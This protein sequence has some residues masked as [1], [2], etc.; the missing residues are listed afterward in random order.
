MNEVIRPTKKFQSISRRFSYAF[1]GVVTLILIAFA[2]T[3]IIVN[4][5]KI[6]SE[7]EKRLDNALKLAEISLPT[8]LW[9]LDND[10][11]DDFIE[12]LFLDESIVFV[13]VLWGG[14][15][16]SKKVRE[17]F[18]KME[19]DYFEQ[20]SKFIKRK[21]N[22]IF[23]NNKVGTIRLA[24]SM[25][26]IK[27]ELIVTISGIIA[28]TTMIII[29]IAITSLVIT[30]R[31]ITNPISRLLEATQD[32]ADGNFQQQITAMPGNEL[33]KLAHGFN[34]MAK[35]LSQLINELKYRNDLSR[36][37]ISTRVLDEI[38]ER[39]VRDVAESGGYDRVRLYLHDEKENVL[40]CQSAFG[41]EKKKLL[42]L[43]LSLSN[44]QN[45]VS[46]WVFRNKI[47]Y[48][49]DDPLN[50]DK[51]EPE[52][53]ESL[54]LN[55]YAVVPLVAGEKSL[56]VMAIDR[57][58]A[59]YPFSEDIINSLIAFA[60]TAA[61][62]IENSLLYS[63]LEK[64][65][66]ERTCQLEIANK[67]L[68][69]LDQI[70]SDF[71]S[72]VSHELRTPLTSILGFASI[73]KKRFRN[74]LIPNLDLTE[75]KVQRNTER[76][77]ESIEIII[78]EGERLSRL[79]NDVL[80]LAKIESGKMEWKSLDISVL[81]IVQQSIQT[82]SPLAKVKGLEIDI[83]TH[84]NNFQFTGDP[85]RLMQVVTNLL[86]NAIK[87]TKQGFII[88][89]LEKNDPVIT[90]K[91]KDSGVGLDHEDLSQIFDKFKQVGDTLTDKPKGTGLGLPICKEIIDYYQGSI[92][93]ESKPEKGSTFVF[94]L[95]MSRESVSAS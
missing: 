75:K 93:A 8:P 35:N 87:F 33:G 62:A 48:V 34:T 82:I 43:K 7:L 79:I 55:N 15:V 41:V 28:L 66:Q 88:C 56:G 58:N 54:K 72:A 30:K 74:S 94:T 17:P 76:T 50:D 9:N 39:V 47:P 14:Q 26:S 89:E 64:R 68:K 44:G 36:A 85:D 77:Q 29:A 22:I 11:V 25:D 27:K 92:W 61:L 32:I 57:I 71:L 20:E 65:V 63:N 38:I 49:V 73:I 59:G 52:L 51:C 60:N 24:M 21:S 2:A 78:E 40:V 23:E 91:V 18:K 80:D 3:A 70:K 10:I 37:L 95:P 84:G 86:S 67:R 1:I 90:V 46:T 19:G 4:S 45:G 83:K 42:P 12:A 5:E 31:S 16:V 6:H 53:L 81:D 69:E 13:E